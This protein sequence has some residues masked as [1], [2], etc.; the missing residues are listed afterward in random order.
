MKHLRLTH[1]RI[2]IH[3][4]LFHGMPPRWKR[5][6][7]D[8]IHDAELLNAVIP[9]ETDLHPAGTMFFDMMPTLQ[10]VF[11][12]ACRRTCT[13][14]WPEPCKHL[15]N[16]WLSSKAWRAAGVHGD[17]HPSGAIHGP[18]V[19]LDNET[20]SAII[21][22]EEL[23]LSPSDEVSRRSLRRFFKLRLAQHTTRQCIDF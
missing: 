9:S 5:L 2:V 6:D 8:T 15:N 17:P 18:C 23:Q 4:R 14:K 20:A 10:Y 1:L 3:Y 22:R 11:L 19:E 16:P 13:G 12:T 21:D 7:P